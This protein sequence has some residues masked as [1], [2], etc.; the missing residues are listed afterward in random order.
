[1]NDEVP[2][3]QAPPP[4][5]ELLVLEVG[6]LDDQGDHLLVVGTLPVPILELEVEHPGLMHRLKAG[7]EDVAHNFVVPVHLKEEGR[8]AAE[9]RG[10]SKTL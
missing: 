5:V 2:T 9:V 7:P 4:V 10:A 1:M 3:Y 6:V 8:L